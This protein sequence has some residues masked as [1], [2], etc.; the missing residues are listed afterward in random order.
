MT[1]GRS[2]YESGHVRRFAHPP[3]SA[4]DG[5]ME[6]SSEGHKRDKFCRKR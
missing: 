2:E 3:E 1:S 6:T 4:H 5:N